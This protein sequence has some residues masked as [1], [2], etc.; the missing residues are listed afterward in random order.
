MYDV[1]TRFPIAAEVIWDTECQSFGSWGFA[2]DPNGE[3]K[4]TPALRPSGIWASARATESLRNQGPDNIIYNINLMPPA[5]LMVEAQKCT[6]EM[7]CSKYRA[8]VLRLLN[9]FTEKLTLIN[10]TFCH[11]SSYY[12]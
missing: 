5:L 6:A 4:P 11:I 1:H 3:I 8:F 9:Y 10:C 2:P 7:C 12:K